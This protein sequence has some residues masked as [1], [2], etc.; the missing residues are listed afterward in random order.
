MIRRPPRST[1]TDTLF[2]YTTLFRSL[3]VEQRRGVV[4]ILEDEGGREIERHRP[5][6]GRRIGLLAG[7]ERQGCRFQKIRVRHGGSIARMK[8]IG[9]SLWA[10]PCFSMASPVQLALNTENL[11]A[12]CRT[13]K[14]GRAHV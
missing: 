14:I 4:G 12:I 8:N 7:M 2:P 13:V 9:A 5:C 11:A 1:R 6:A 3:Q 10:T